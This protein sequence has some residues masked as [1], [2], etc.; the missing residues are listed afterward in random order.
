MNL[1]LG[2]CSARLADGE[3]RCTALTRSSD[4]FCPHHRK[5]LKDSCKK[6]KDTAHRV[7]QL[8]PHAVTNREA[9]PSLCTSEDI[10]RAM[11]VTTQY[12]DALKE[13]AQRRNAHT[14]Q[15]FSDG[16]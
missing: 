13:E 8:L 9:L 3:T 1:D 12:L 5:E 7:E 14:K 16:A 6:Y 15:F 10:G 4:H 11:E 2:P